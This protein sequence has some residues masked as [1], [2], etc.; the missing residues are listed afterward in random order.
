MFIGARKNNVEASN[1]NYQRK[2]KIDNEI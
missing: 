2:Y 1:Q